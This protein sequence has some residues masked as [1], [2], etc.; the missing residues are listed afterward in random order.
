VLLLN[1]QTLLWYCF[2]R[3]C[4]QINPKSDIV[5]AKGRAS[6]RAT[7]YLNVDFGKLDGRGE[8]STSK[9]VTQLEALCLFVSP[10]K[11]LKLCTDEKAVESPAP[12][13]ITDGLIHA[14][15]IFVCVFK[16]TYCSFNT[17][18][19][20]AFQA[21]FVMRLASCSAKTRGVSTQSTTRSPRLF[22]SVLL[23]A[24]PLPWT[25]CTIVMMYTT[26]LA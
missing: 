19:P 17:Q 12:S 11:K 24:L 18:R 21:S 16:T 10:P 7:G 13:E 6:C 8:F 23:K 4:S 14:P 9:P 15:W 1:L 2:E 20:E 22:S 3:P 26:G 5:Q 25:V